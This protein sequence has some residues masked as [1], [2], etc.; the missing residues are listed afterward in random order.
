M[1][2]QVRTSNLTEGVMRE[3]REMILTCEI[4]LGANLPTRK[5][6]ATRFGV[7]AST[8]H[9]AIQGLAAVGLV[10][11]RPGKGTWARQDSENSDPSGCAQ[12][13]AGGS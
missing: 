12:G 9:G 7:R 8:V 6:L 2:R 1:N 3:I 11:S 4:E 13:T 5:E 10:D